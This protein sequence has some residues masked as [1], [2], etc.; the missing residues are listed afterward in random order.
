VLFS[1]DVKGRTKVAVVV[2][3]DQPHRPAADRRIDRAQAPDVEML[4]Q[5]QPAQLDAWWSK[6]RTRRHN[7]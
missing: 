1:F 6:G 7:D 2:A 5:V 4:V 3:K